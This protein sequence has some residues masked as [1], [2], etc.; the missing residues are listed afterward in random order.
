MN[1]YAVNLVVVFRIQSCLSF[2][3]VELCKIG[4]D[5]FKAPVKQLTKVWEND[6]MFDAVLEITSS[7]FG[8]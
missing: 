3:C 2:S 6:Q 5:E 8:Q 7:S 1:V 4:L